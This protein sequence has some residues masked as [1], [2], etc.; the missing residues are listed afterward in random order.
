MGHGGNGGKAGR[1][2]AQH[3]STAVE[4]CDKSINPVTHEGQP[5]YSHQQLYYNCDCRPRSKHV[6]Y[7]GVRSANHNR[8]ALD[9]RVC[10]GGGSKWE[11]MLYELLDDEELIQLYA[12][13]AH[14]LAK[15]KEPVMQEGVVVHPDKKRWDVTV[16]VPGGLL[17][18][19]HGEGHSSRLVSKANNTDYNLAER[20]LKDWLYV[21]TAME[22]GWSVLWLW[23]NENITSDS[24]QVSLWAQ[25]LKKAVTHVQ[26]QGLPQLFGA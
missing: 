19:M 6:V 23:V 22:Q 14:S 13:E 21:V 12:V 15:P 7:R 26:A 2:R 8:T 11:C 17:I 16:V 3:S 20:Q 25:Q 5:S 9:C 24:T 4:R 18:E 10:S 1:R